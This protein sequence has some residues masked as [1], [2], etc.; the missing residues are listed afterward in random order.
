MLE[1][2]Q[3]I[4]RVVNNFVWGAPAMI[5]ILGVGLLLTFRTGFL[6]IRK[7]PYAIKTTIGRIFRKREASDGSMTPFQAVCT[8][9][10][11]TVG[12]G[13]IAGIAGA[14]AIG[15]PGAVF[16]MWVSAFLGICTKFAEVTLA[17]HFRER[18]A[19][20]DLVGGP[21]YYIKNGLSKHWHWLA[22]AFAAFGVLTVFGTGNATQ[23][24]TI[25]TAINSALLNYNI[26]NESSISIINLVQG[27]L[28]AALVGLILL[29]G[30]KRIGH[31]TERLVPFMALFYIILALG[32]VFLNIEQV[33][34]VFASIITGAF[35]PAA[36]TGGV[37]G[38]I[39][40]SMQKGVAR[41]IFSNEAGLGT[42]SIAHAC[43]DTKKPVKQGL[44]GIFEVFTDTIIICTL[45]ALVILCSGIPIHYGIDA[46]AE[47]TIRGFTSTYG[48]WVSIFTAVALCCFAF[49]TI[50]GWGLYGA[51]CIE[52]LF[53]EKV[54]KPFMIVYSLVAILGATA[55]LGLLWG[56]AETFN[57]LMA[58]PNLIAVFL[59]SGTVVKLTKA[60]FATEGKDK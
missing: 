1:T 29:G 4:N 52:F 34:A 11:A 22:Y 46:G 60:Y 50:I 28:I 33:P 54:I 27:I 43:A 35:N 15:G 49:S 9:L 25:T 5:C 12:T 8:A 59:L 56:I 10:A 18:N 53:N 47:L 7:F 38:S 13:N 44:F 39:F 58:I 41:G 20:G 3:S 36:V 21:M 24:N 16:W 31:V 6:Q 45:T 30:V 17:V 23:V 57:G 51:R 42:G 26:I 40:L 55:D 32:V 14:I 19:H 2:I 37:V 48:S